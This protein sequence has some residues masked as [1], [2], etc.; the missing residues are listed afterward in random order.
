M[1][2]RS[3]WLS[4]AVIGWVPKALYPSIHAEW[5]RG[6]RLKTDTWKTC[7]KSSTKLVSSQVFV[8]FC[9]VEVW[10]LKDCWKF[11]KTLIKTCTWKHWEI[12][13]KCLWGGITYDSKLVWEVIVV[14]WKFVVCN[15]KSIWEILVIR[16]E[17]LMIVL[18]VIC[19]VLLINWFDN[20]IL[21]EPL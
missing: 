2:F 19:W 4:S 14:C 3:I 17:S 13:S 6:I 20:F 5:G 8:L 16:F 1:Y 18:K 15:S 7:S 21:V 12:L 9:L 11:Y 10:S